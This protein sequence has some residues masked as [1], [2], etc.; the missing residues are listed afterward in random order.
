MNESKSDLVQ[1]SAQNMW[2]KVLR[3]VKKPLTLV[4]GMRRVLLFMINQDGKNQLRLGST[5]A[6]N[7]TFQLM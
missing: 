4:Q 1:P 5:I 3:V 2:G 6:E 7:E